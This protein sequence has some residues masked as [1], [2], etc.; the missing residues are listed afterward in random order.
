[1]KLRERGLL[2]AALN[3]VQGSC[4]LPRDALVRALWSTVARG[5]W[6]GRGRAGTSAESL[7]VA[8][9][10]ISKIQG[11]QVA[12]FCVPT[13]LCY[14]VFFSSLEFCVVNKMR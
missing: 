4:P 11:P 5:P 9:Q 13:C 7:P 14:R 6:R 8:E 2:A 10:A 12:A 3:G 1:M